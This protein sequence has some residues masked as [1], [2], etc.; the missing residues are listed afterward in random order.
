MG[1]PPHRAYTHVRTRACTHT[2]THTHTRLLHSVPKITFPNLFETPGCI[3]GAGCSPEHP[4]RTWEWPGL[5]IAF[6][7]Q[8]LGQKKGDRFFGGYLAIMVWSLIFPRWII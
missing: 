1:A 3:R 2:Y 6:A 8:C 5:L 4:E 7:R